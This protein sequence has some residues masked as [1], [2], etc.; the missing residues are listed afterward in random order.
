MS[1]PL[2]GAALT[3]AFAVLGAIGVANWLQL[4]ARDTILAVIAVAVIAVFG[5]FIPILRLGRKS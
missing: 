3:W 2:L 5:A 1:K 4:S